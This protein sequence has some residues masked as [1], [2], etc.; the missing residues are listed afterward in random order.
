MKEGRSAD[1]PV[2]SQPRTLWPLESFEP[3]LVCGAR[4]GQECP[5]S[6]IT[7]GLPAVPNFFLP[8]LVSFCPRFRSDRHYSN[9]SFRL[10]IPNANRRKPIK[11]ARFEWQFAAYC[12]DEAVGAFVVCRHQGHG[13]AWGN[14]PIRN[15]RI[16]HILETIK[17]L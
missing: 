14:H 17:F 16:R 1:F 12:A 4:C 5:R 13:F 2:R 6:A 15:G 9:P 11:P 10:S 3:H 8:G 7:E